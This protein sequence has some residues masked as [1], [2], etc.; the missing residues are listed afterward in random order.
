MYKSDLVDFKIVSVFIFTCF[1]FYTVNACSEVY[2]WKDEHGKVHFGDRPPTG[3]KS[4]NI[5]NKLDHINISTDFSSPELLLEQIQQKEREQN[6]KRQETLD[7]R[8]N[9]PSLADMCRDAESYLRAIEGRVVFTDDQGKEIKVSEKER[10]NK[11]IK[12]KAIIRQKC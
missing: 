2:Q 10:Q 8:K 7:K 12:M 9:M 1:M 4:D 5:S 11:V 3:I 6:K